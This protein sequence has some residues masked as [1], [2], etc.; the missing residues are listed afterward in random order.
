MISAF[1]MMLGLVRWPST[2][3][4]LGQAY[5]TASP[6]ERATLDAVFAGL[7]SYLGNFIGEFVGDLTLNLFFLLVAYAMLRSAQRR[8]W[9]GVGACLRA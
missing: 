3:W 4:E 2:H 9:L 6:A 1:S 5:A 8:R 7:N